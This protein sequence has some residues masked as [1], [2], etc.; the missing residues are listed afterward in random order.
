MND[1]P[2]NRIKNLI[3]F[4]FYVIIKLTN[5]GINMKFS[6]VKADIVNLN[7]DEDRFPQPL[8]ELLG[9]LVTFIFNIFA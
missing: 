5:G 2:K 8:M 6:V 3:I 7:V 4:C 9:R 1:I